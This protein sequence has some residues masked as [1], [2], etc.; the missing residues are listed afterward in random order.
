MQLSVEENLMEMLG[1]GDQTYHG[2]K[3]IGSVLAGLSLRYEI[4]DNKCFHDYV[5]VKKSSGMLGI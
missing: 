5:T 4:L 2:C 3:V 1:Q